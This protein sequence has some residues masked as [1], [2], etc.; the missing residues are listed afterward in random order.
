MVSKPLRHS[1]IKMVVCECLH[2][3]HKRQG[4]V[5]CIYNISMMCFLRRQQDQA[6][7]SGILPGGTVKGTGEVNFRNK[8]TQREN[9]RSQ[10][11]HDL[12]K[13]KTKN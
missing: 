3:Q 10:R 12:I 13:N 4:E 11:K 2:F 1:K 7:M 9:V 8:V 5:S 6:T